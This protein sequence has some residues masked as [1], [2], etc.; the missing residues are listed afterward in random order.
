[1]ERVRAGELVYYRFRRL[2]LV[3]GVFTRLGGVSAPP[4]DSLNLGSTVGDDPRA[5]ARNHALVWQALALDGV[6][7]STV[8]QVHGA[9]TIV[10][11]EPTLDR[12]HL[13]RADGIIT[14]RPNLA[15]TMRFA[16]CTPIF[17]HD[18]VRG[19]IGL[20]H[21]G[22]RGTVVGAGPS[23]V[24]KM[25]EVFGCRPAD[26]WAGIG[27][28]IGPA[29]YEVGPEVVTAVREAFEYAGGLV[30]RVGSGFYL[31]LW[32]ANQL[33]LLRVGVGRVD[34]AGICTASR[35]DEFFSHRAEGGRTGRFG[36]VL[37]LRNHGD[38]DGE[39]CR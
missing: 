14:D 3:H 36:A 11:T 10:A 17:L 8:W 34:V 32:A 9:E 20:A 2:P 33:A 19:V 6:Q 29:R 39:D 24:C 25:V 13:V 38:D 21:A 15:L 26:I 5:V 23:A 28:S 31:D 1:M 30:R 27:P 37:T 16:D 18:P 22:W 35:T 4:W 7:P 12:D